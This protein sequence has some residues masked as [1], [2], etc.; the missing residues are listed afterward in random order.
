MQT[1]ISTNNKIESPTQ[2]PD[3]SNKKPSKSTQQ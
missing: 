2:Q 1:E 3:T